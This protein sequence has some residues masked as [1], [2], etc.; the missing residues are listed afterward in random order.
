MEIFTLPNKFENVEFECLAEETLY[1]FRLH[2]FREMMYATIYADNELVI[3]GQRCVNDA[4]LI[5]DGY[6]SEKGNFRFEVNGDDYPWW[7]NFNES[8]NL[9][10]YTADE[11]SRME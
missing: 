1:R 11:I 4:W 6:M 3:S 8:T 9:V 10:Y 5:P 2:V 7:A